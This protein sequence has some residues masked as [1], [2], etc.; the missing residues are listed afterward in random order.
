MALGSDPG[1]AEINVS[2]R[3]DSSSLLP[4]GERQVREFPARPAVDGDDRGL[5]A[6][7]RRSR[8][9]ARP[10]LLKIDVQGLELEVLR[11]AGRYSGRSTRRWSNAR[12]SS[13]TK[14]RPWP[15]K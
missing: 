6:R 4:I 7:R 14:A 12:S 3:D 10:C 9:L 15:T 5:D 2:G 11:E 8:G 1:S 13:S